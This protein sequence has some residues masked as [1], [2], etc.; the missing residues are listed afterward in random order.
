MKRIINKLI[1]AQSKYNSVIGAVEQEI[2][3]KVEFDFSIFWQPSD[4]FVIVDDGMGNAPISKC[5]EI[6]NKRGRLTKDDFDGV[7]I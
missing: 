4:G 2:S 5:L 6:I 3:D 7:C 1:N